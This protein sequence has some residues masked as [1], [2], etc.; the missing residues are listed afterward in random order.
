MASVHRLSIYSAVAWLT[1]RRRASA[2]GVSDGAAPP[3]PSQELRAE[4]PCVPGPELGEDPA[5]AGG[6]EA[7]RRQ[8][9]LGGAVR[10]LERHLPGRW[11]HQ[12]R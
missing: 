8:R 11:Q 10:A 2:C 7:R 12:V 5:E 4:A 1:R 9:A 6:G 3:S